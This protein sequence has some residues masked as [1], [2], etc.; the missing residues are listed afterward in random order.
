M[1]N[2]KSLVTGILMIFLALVSSGQEWPKIYG[3]N[4][5]SNGRKVL[6]SYDKGFYICGSTLKDGS[7]FKFGWL[8]RTDINGNQLWQ[9]K[10]G[11]WNQENFVFDIYQTK[12]NELLLSGGTSKMDYMDDPLV[13]K[14]NPC[15]EIEWCKIFQAEDYNSARGIVELPNGEIMALLAYYGGGGHKFRISLVKMDLYGEPIW[16]KYL[17]QDSNMVNEEGQFLDLMNDGNLLV[18]GYTFTPS[19]KPYFIKTDTAAEELW[20]IKWPYGYGGEARRSAFSSS[21]SIY[22]A[23]YLRF[24]GP[25]NPYILKFTDQGEMISGYPLLADTIEGGGANSILLVNDSI[26]YAGLSWTQDPIY[27]EGFSDI[28]KADTFGVLKIQRNLMSNTT[29]APDD[30]ILTSDNKIVTIG[31]Y[32]VNGPWNIYLWKMNL[33]LEDDTLYTQPSVYDSLCPY[34]I[35]S[36]TLELDCSL[37]VKI[38]EIPTKEEYESTI[39]IS[40]NPARD[41]IVL[42]MPEIKLSDEMELA[43]Y[44]IFGQDVMK[45]RAVMQNRSISL[46]ISD[47]SPGVYL[48]S[49]KDAKSRILKGKFE[50][51][52]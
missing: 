44:N 26:I 37:F 23:S 15:G 27:F 22:N 34:G 30:I 5:L 21:G 45:A 48:V 28:V 39:K 11:Q 31:S 51:L 9:K 1:A 19:V 40:P 33:D 32:Y 12:H 52:K 2:P 6:E 41:W 42:T 50:V 46:N 43:I 25:S 3:G 16:I 29:F 8:I 49:C 14:L 20:N 7:H 4:I 36:D 47:L 24:S 18:S 10:I 17:A 38:N 35:T 13:M